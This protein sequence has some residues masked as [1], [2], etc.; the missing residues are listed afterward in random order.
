[1]VVSSCRN[2]HEMVCKVLKDNLDEL[3]AFHT[4]QLLLDRGALTGMSLG[5]QHGYE[6]EQEPCR[7]NKLLDERERRK[8]EL[9]FE[10]LQ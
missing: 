10:Q 9:S 1:M 3:Q 6:N 4:R 7:V 5:M 2:I 8:T